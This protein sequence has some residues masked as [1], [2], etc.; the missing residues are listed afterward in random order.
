MRLAFRRGQAQALRQLYPQPTCRQPSLPTCGGRNPGCETRSGAF[1]GGTDRRSRPRP[2]ASSRNG[3]HLR[4]SFDALS[5]FGLAFFG[6][7]C[8]CGHR[9]SASLRRPRVKDRI[10]CLATAQCSLRSG[11]KVRPEDVSLTAPL[12]LPRFLAFP[13]NL[14]AKAPRR[15]RAHARTPLLPAPATRGHRQLFKTLDL[16]RHWALGL[17]VGTP[18]S[19]RV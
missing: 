10:C 18:P 5:Y 3:P 16:A 1:F 8:P 4:R 15:S 2:H 13:Q 14:D 9:G 6:R 7:L 19:T 11:S 17:V 12:Q